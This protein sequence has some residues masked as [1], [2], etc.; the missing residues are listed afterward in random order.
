MFAGHPIGRTSNL[1]RMRGLAF[2][3]RCDAVYFVKSLPTFRDNIIVLP[4]YQVYREEG[5]SRLLGNI[6]TIYKNIERH[7]P[8]ENNLYFSECFEPLLISR[9]YP[10]KQFPY[11][12]KSILKFLSI[13]GISLF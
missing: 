6:V 10:H 1:F 12:I 4:I 2:S 3:E 13:R 9:F 7:I 5:G 11:H 8:L